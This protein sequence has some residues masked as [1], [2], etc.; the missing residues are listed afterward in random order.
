M[1]PKGYL[2]GDVRR[3]LDAD[4]QWNTPTGQAYLYHSCNDW[5]IG[6]DENIRV[7]IH[8]LQQLIEK[9]KTP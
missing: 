3:A 6:D 1:N 5:C 2:A 4:P 7:L 9:E 8:D